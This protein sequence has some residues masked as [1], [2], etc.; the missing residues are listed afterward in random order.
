SGGIPLIGLILT[1]ITAIILGMGLP[2]TA[3]YLILATVVAPA[4]ADMGVPLLTAHMFVFFFGCVSTI[5]PP[6]AL[7]S[8]V[9]A[10]I[11]RAD[12]NEVG[13]TAFRYG[14]VCYLLPF[15][16]FY[17]PGLLSQGTAWEVASTFMTGVVG[18]FFLA[19][20]IVGYF[21]THLS[22][23]GRLISGAS[24]ILLL[25][26]GLTSDV[27]GL[28]LVIAWTLISNSEV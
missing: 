19:T 17:G 4:L 1:M 3:A 7:A 22:L 28:V 18:V 21:R 9:A 13:W 8:Y 12:I 24:G 23:A 27:I 20:A 6:V 2:T 25:S 15:A 14:L 11:A 16:F 26:Q 10:G 5:T